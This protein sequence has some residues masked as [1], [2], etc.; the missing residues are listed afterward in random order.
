MDMIIIL[1]LSYTCTVGNM[2][3]I[4]SEFGIR[5]GSR[6]KCDDFLQV[7]NLNINILHV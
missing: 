7:Y 3:K 2:G 4:L 5:N 6:L 1:N